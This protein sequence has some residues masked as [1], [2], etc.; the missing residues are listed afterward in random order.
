V[1]AVA[2]VE[3]GRRQQAAVAGAGDGRLGRRLVD[4]RPLGPGHQVGRGGQVA[5]LV[6]VVEGQV[7]AGRALN[8]LGGVHA[9]AHRVLGV[10]PERGC[11]AHVTE[12][13]GEPRHRDGDPL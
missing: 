13:P 7:A 12:Q 5:H 3:L 9:V 6:V 10:V 4:D 8:H 11:G 2:V 1:P